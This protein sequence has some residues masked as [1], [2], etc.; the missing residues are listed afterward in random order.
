MAEL[1]EVLD[2]SRRLTALPSGPTH[3]AGMSCSKAVVKVASALRRRCELAHPSV[4]LSGLTM[5]DMRAGLSQRQH[6]SSLANIPDARVNP[7]GVRA[8]ARNLLLDTLQMVSTWTPMALAWRKSRSND[9]SPQLECTRGEGGSW[10]APCP[11]ANRSISVPNID[12]DPWSP[13][14]HM[15]MRK[16]EASG[17]SREQAEG[18]TQ[19]L[20][21]MLCQD[22]DKL[23]DLYV[24]KEVLKRVRS[25]GVNGTLITSLTLAACAGC[26]LKS[27]TLT[28]LAHYRAC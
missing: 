11:S 9:Y 19:H 17:M 24:T 5:S 23:A 2:T 13:T 25:G 4:A 14:K 18:L 6:S 26:R 7:D 21:Q 16:F 12:R 20:T 8:I 1:Q 27:V 22:R 15:Q 10:G 28:T 3:R